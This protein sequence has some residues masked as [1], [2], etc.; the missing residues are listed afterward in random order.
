VAFALLEAV[1]SHFFVASRL[2]GAGLAAVEIFE[3]E[4]YECEKYGR[5]KHENTKFKRFKNTNSRSL[6]FAAS[7][8]MR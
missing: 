1:V 5:E 3:R 2:R 4:K 7:A 6:V 8:M